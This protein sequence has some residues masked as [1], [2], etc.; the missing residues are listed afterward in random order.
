MLTHTLQ[1]ISLCLAKFRWN[2]YT[3]NG[4]FSNVCHLDHFKMI[5]IKYNYVNA[6]KINSSRVGSDNSLDKHIAHADHSIMLINQIVFFLLLC[7]SIAIF[8][9]E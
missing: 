7:V 6:L 3:N 4:H 5:L 1:Y 2:A 9:G 8:F